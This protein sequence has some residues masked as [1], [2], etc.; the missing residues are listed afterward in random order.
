[1]MYQNQ[2]ENFDEDDITMMKNHGKTK[3]L[4]EEIKLRN[5]THPLDS[6]QKNVYEKKK[7]CFHWDFQ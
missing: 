2:A 6:M 4:F 3:E 7:T 5:G 1:M